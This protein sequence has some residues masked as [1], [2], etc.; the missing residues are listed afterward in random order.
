MIGSR[1]AITGQVAGDNTFRNSSRD[2][3]TL[4]VSGDLPRYIRALHDQA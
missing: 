3:D 1:V 2:I 4:F